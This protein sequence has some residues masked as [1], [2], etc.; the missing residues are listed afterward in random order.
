MLTWEKPVFNSGF[1]LWREDGL[2]RLV[3][4]QEARLGM[5]DIKELLRLVAALDPAGRCPILAE[6]A[7]Q[8]IVTQEARALICRAGRSHHAVAL[9]TADLECRLQGEIFKR[10]QRPAFP[11]R[12]FGFREEALRWVR[13]RAQAAVFDRRG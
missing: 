1:E 10:L 11:F 13:E 2:L 6:C 12:V 8:V 7:G 9:L 3:L 5:A 4:T